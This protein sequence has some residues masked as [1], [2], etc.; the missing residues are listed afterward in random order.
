MGKLKT[1]LADVVGL[2]ISKETGYW[3]I[4]LDEDNA[5]IDYAYFK[6]VSKNT[7]LDSCEKMMI[8]ADIVQK[9]SFLEDM[10]Y[11]WMDDY[12]SKVSTIVTEVYANYQEAMEAGKEKVDVQLMIANKI[13][14]FNPMNEEAMSVGCMLMSK[15]GMHQE[16]R[17]TYESFAQEYHKLYGEVYPI[18]LKEILKRS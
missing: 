14:Q 4:K 12:K 15:T 16:A 1:I 17:I 9:G 13:M 7:G 3:T 2:E 18:A 8:I 11:E 6:A 10:N 5:Y